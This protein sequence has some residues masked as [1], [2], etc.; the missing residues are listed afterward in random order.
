MC[1]ALPAASGW[2]SWPAD[3]PTVDGSVPPVVSSPDA[4][5]P[6]PETD[7]AEGAAQNWHESFRTWRKK[8][9]REIDSRLRFLRK[10]IDELVVVE[11]TQVAGFNQFFDDDTSSLIWSYGVGLDQKFSNSLFGGIQYLHRDLAV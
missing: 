8:R 1:Y 11:P 4:A 7:G 6:V 3:P 9:L 2:A 10:R 5:L